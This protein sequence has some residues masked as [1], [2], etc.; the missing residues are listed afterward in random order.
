[1]YYAG[2]RLEELRKTTITS[3]RIAGLQAE[4]LSEHN[5]WCEISGS[6]GGEY[7]DEGLLGYSTV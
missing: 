7:E 6:H 5:V 2:I 4:I 3:V 1:M